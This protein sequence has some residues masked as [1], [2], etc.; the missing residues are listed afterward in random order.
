GTG[1]SCI[2]MRLVRS[3]WMDEYD[4]TIED[5][6]STTC[7]V[8]GETF[9]L[10]IIDTAGQ[11]E[12]RGLLSGLWQA[13]NVADAYLLVYD[14]TNLQT[15]RALEEFDDLISNAQEINHA[16]NTTPPVKLV[17]GNKC[18]LATYR[19]VPSQQGLNWARRHGCGFMETSAL[20]SVNI[21]ETFSLMVRRVR[22][23]RILEQK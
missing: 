8:D 11:E 5:S 17:A 6:Y 13:G 14:I 22:D 7:V 4:P 19:A 10:D 1:K 15:L 3:Q 20:M 21:E 12:Y 23:N 18:D 9:E 16:P 2:T